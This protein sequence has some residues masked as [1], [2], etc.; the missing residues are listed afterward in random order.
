MMSEKGGGWRIGCVATGI[1]V[2][3]D[4]FEILTILDA[5]LHITRILH[6]NGSPRV[7]CS[8]IPV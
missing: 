1:D 7:P 4:D 6:F 3:L 2:R 8:C 5:K